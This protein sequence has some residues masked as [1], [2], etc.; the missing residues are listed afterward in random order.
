[1]ANNV[2][3][4][5]DLERKYN[6]PALLGLSKNVKMN[7]KSI[8][9][10]NIELHSFIE[11]TIG[12]L[13][14]LNSQIDGKTEIWFNSGVPELDN[15]PAKEWKEEER[16]DHLGDLYYDTDTGYAYRFALQGT[17]YIWIRIIDTDVTEA[18]EIASV[19]KDTADGKR[20]V[21]MDKPTTPYDKGDLYL[22]DEELYICNISRVSGDYE[23]NDFVIATKYTDD[24]KANEAIDNLNNF[25]DVTFKES[26]EN[27][28]N[29]IDG[30]IS[31]WYYSGEPTLKNAP[32][33]EWLLDKDKLSHTG[34]LYYDK[35]TGHTYI[36]EYIDST[37]KWSRVKDEDIVEAMSLANSAKDTADNKRQIFV[38]QPTTP[39]SCG[40]LW[41]KEEE[42]FI[43][44][45]ERVKGDFVDG[46]WI[47]NLKY[48]DNTYAQAIVD[49]LGGNTT[50]VLEGT[51]TQYTK[52][53]VKFIDL[54]TGGS[55]VINGANI[56]T[57]NIDTDNVTIGN[58][59]V[60]MD[61]DGIKLKNGAKVV[62]ENGLM[63]T[64]LF[65]SQDS[66]RMCGYQGDDPTGLDNSQVNKVGVKV[67]FNIPKGLNIVAAK[68]TLFHAPTKWQCSDISGNMSNIWGYCRNLKMYKATNINNRIVEAY[69]GSEYTETNNTTYEEISGALGTSGYTPSVPGDT[70]YNTESKESIDIKDH[71]SSGLNEIL[72]QTGDTATQTWNASEISKRTAFVYA[73]L[74]IDGYMS[75]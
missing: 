6:F 29:Q 16:K 27:L 57:G 43:C 12:E 71:I 47:N 62:G 8:T 67:Q 28:T 68:L 40:D 64:Y 58:G 38:V 20:R 5:K 56:S 74:K 49:E 44:Q 72:I 63:N 48:T 9:K 10:I 24:T 17:T 45:V 18:L 65:T 61:K 36:F 1:M 60:S 34:D 70:T 7:E 66:F 55:T 3:T 54:A 2:R 46:D 52:S 19:A 14:V 53:W 15:I 39:Y 25:V 50:K 32:A 35:L 59:N 42:I 69:F 41:I 13:E 30:K 22:K 33:S 21:F 37:Y 26:M 11:S 51:V 23:E 75:Y 4:P 73:M 31:T